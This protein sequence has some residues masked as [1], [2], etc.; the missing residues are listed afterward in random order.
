VTEIIK[1]IT[2]VFVI[3]FTVIKNIEI[4]AKIFNSINPSTISLKDSQKFEGEKKQ[5]N[6]LLRIF[7]TRNM[8]FF[9]F[10]FG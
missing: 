10:I 9:P 2:F 1:A 8:I 3:I 6:Q 5:L 4:D 7:N